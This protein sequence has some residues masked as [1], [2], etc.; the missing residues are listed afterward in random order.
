MK[1]KVD[2]DMKEEKKENP[3]E[4]E[5]NENTAAETEA[6]E[7]AGQSKSDEELENVKKELADLKDKYMRS[8][9]EYDNFR[10]RSVKDRENA[11]KFSKADVLTKLLPVI[12]NFERAAENDA[13]SF[14]DYKKGIIMIHNQFNEILKNL[15]VEAFGEKGEPFDPNFHSAVMH[16]DDEEMGENVIAD[17]FSKGYKIGEQVLRPATVKVAN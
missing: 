13:A 9:A 4:T 17:V 3:Q 2:T 14:E 7:G 11:Y 1:G 12:D 16:I 6:C 15:D 8:L 5:I 10:K